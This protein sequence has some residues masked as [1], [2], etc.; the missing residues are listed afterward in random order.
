MPQR[1]RQSTRG[2]SRRF[3]AVYAKAFLLAEESTRSKSA[4]RRTTFLMLPADLNQT[5]EADF[6][7]S[8]PRRRSLFCEVCSAS[9][10]SAGTTRS[11]RLESPSVVIA[12][13]VWGGWRGPDIQG[14]G[15][16][17]P[18]NTLVMH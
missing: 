3:T 7:S 8:T 14:R 12:G 9:K 18:P 6:F 13:G 2:G 1:S 10:R 4:L 16:T 11:I 5:N 15:Q 17:I